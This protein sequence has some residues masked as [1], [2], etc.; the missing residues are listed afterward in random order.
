MTKED[1]IAELQTLIRSGAPREFATARDVVFG[2]EHNPRDI[3]ADAARSYLEKCTTDY[4][5]LIHRLVRKKLHRGGTHVYA[6]TSQARKLPRC[7]SDMQ[8]E[9][10]RL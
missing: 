3:Y 4:V 7:M 5:E 8:R 6:T 10:I 1:L 9:D 2:S